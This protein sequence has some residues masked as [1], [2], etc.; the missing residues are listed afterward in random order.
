MDNQITLALQDLGF[1]RIR[2]TPVIHHPIWNISARV[3]TFRAESLRSVKLALK[4][5]C[6]ELGFRVRMNEIVASV[7]RGRLNAALAL[8]RKIALQ[9]RSN[10]M[11]GGFLNTLRL[12]L[13]N[14]NHNHRWIPAR[15]VGRQDTLVFHNE[16]SGQIHRQEAAWHPDG[17]PRKRGTGRTRTMEA[18]SVSKCLRLVAGRPRN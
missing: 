11:A 18:A 9:W 14:R 12:P 17:D 7:Y 3:G 16:M 5:V 2:V 8:I 6:S 4:T 10:T 13:N 15:A 1:Q